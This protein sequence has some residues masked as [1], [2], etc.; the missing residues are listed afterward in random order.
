MAEA[1]VFSTAEEDLE[2]NANQR[3][4]KIYNEEILSNEDDADE[5]EVLDRY[6]KEYEQ[7]LLDEKTKVSKGNAGSVSSEAKT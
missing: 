6:E 7:I 3:F 2:Q 5:E 1:D 4:V